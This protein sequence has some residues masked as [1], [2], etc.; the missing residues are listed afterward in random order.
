MS[1]RIDALGRRVENDPFF[2]ASALADYARSEHL[3]NEDLAAALGC[4]VETLGPLRLCRRPRPDPGLFKQDIER[5]AARFG[6]DADLLAQAVRRSDA[7][8]SLRR[9][10][11]GGRGLLMAARDRQAQEDVPSAGDG[12]GDPT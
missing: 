6:V 4:A 9:A 8:S 1:S 5:I 2:L 12:E 11:T 10:A 7:L 3:D